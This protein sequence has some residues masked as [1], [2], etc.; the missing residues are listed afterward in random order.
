MWAG[1]TRPST[2]PASGGAPEGA[3][4]AATNTRVNRDSEGLPDLETG[5]ESDGASFD[6]P[7]V[8]DVGAA[9]VTKGEE[10]DVHAHTDTQTH[11]HKHT[12]TCRHTHTSTQTHTHMQAHREANNNQTRAL[13]S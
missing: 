6:S 8:G 2:E 9:L 4:A 1:L 10:E 7:H 11:T 5:T 13:T 12:H 3:P